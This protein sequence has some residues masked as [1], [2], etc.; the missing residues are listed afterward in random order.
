MSLL[1]ILA[2]YLSGTPLASLANTKTESSPGRFLMLNCK[3][4][5]VD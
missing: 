2:L 1:A 4:A 3:E 5:K